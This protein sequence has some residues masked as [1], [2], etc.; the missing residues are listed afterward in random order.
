MLKS[1]LLLVHPSKVSQLRCD[2][3]DAK[4]FAVFAQ[5]TSMI[6]SGKQQRMRGA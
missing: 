5:R 1:L 2:V 6:V 3:H 4:N